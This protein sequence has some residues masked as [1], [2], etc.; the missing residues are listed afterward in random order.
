[1]R[2][3][4]ARDIDAVAQQ[5]SRSGMTLLSPGRRENDFAHVASFNWGL[6]DGS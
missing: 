3:G 4:F 2:H 1:M 5:R 6:G